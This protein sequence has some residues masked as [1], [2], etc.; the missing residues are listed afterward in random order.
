V[1]RER[2]TPRPDWQAKCEAVGFTF[3]SEDGG[4]WDESA[5]YAFSADEVDVLEATSWTSLINS[6]LRTSLKL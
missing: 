3:H 6:T 4:Y 5:C 2:C 1:R